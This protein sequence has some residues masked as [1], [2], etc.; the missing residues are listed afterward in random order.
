MAIPILMYHNVAEVP[1]ALHPDGRCLYVTPAAFAA[2]MALL[3]RLGWR[4]VSMSDAMPSASRHGLFHAAPRR[5]RQRRLAR[6]IRAARFHAARGHPG[7][8]GG[9]DADHP[10]LRCVFQRA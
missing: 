4:G 5:H 7:A 1:D 9:V 2:Q 6:K 10:R 3:H 8:P